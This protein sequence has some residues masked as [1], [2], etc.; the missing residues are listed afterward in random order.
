[1][2][3]L[4]QDLRYGVRMLLKKPGFTLIAVITL[5]CGIGA[6]TAIFSVTDKLLIRSLA[7]EK[8]QQL[9]LINSVSVNPHFVSNAFSYPNFS[10]Y[11]AQNRVLSGLL[12]FTRTQLDFK[13]D[14]RVERVESE[15]VSGNYFDV[16][17]VRAA[18]GRTFSPE[19]DWTPGTQPVV[20][21]SDGFWRSARL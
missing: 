13:K 2:Q 20:V 5:A 21:V 9:F 6:N 18:R 12:A 8:P 17:D 15:Y 3:M 10:D 16:L 1:M 11:R 14:E 19:E 7:V 4:R